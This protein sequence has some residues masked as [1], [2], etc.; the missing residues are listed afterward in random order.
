MNPDQKSLL[1]RAKNICEKT[2]HDNAAILSE[3]DDAAGR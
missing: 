3:K 1:L 2:I